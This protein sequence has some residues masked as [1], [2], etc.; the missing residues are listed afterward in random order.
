M[1]IVAG[2]DRHATSVECRVRSLVARPVP[3]QIQLQGGASARWGRAQA[4]DQ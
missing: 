4:V 1:P 2:G 3:A